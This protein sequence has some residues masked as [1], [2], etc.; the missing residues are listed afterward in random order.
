MGT[1]FNRL[2]II[3]M[4][5]HYFFIDSSTVLRPGREQN[6]VCAK[7]SIHATIQL[8]RTISTRKGDFVQSPIF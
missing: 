2:L 8:W 7:V 1:V 6:L 5:V 3:V 4:H